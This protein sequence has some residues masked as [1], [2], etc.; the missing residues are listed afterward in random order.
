MIEAKSDVE[1]A[2]LRH[3]LLVNTHSFYKNR[4]FAADIASQDTPFVLGETGY[5]L[6]QG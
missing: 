3:I 1:N 6:V 5:I 4:D 2:I